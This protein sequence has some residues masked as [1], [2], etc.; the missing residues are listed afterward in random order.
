MKVVPMGLTVA[1]QHRNSH[2]MAITHIQQQDSHSISK[3]KRFRSMIYV[4]MIN[5]NI[6]KDRAA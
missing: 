5:Q 1:T 4:G 6:A 3:E 2:T